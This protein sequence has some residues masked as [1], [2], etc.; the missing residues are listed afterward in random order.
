M[1][2]EKKINY[3]HRWTR[4]EAN[5]C[6]DTYHT[7]Y[8]AKHGG[9]LHTAIIG[10]NVGT[11]INKECETFRRYARMWAYK[12]NIHSLNKQF[13]PEQIHRYD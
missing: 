4:K 8:V 6:W 11:Y 1:T 10:G 2:L 9:A 13:P 5:L 12:N 3:M 7:K